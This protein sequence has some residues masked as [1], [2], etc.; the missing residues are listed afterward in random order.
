MS[1]IQRFSNHTLLELVTVLESGDDY[2][3]EAK[4][5]VHTIL[6]LKETTKE[7]IAEAA[8]LY[9]ENRVEQNIRKMLMQGIKP[10]S[11]ILGEEDLKPILQAAFEKYRDKLD[12]H[13]IDTT[14][15]WF[16]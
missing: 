2:T 10:E 8:K 16:V 14:K 1:L 15:Y 12:L 3:L 5:A 11:E 7:E 4:K 6:E 9:W 13:S